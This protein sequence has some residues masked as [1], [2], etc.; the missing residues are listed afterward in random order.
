MP[1]AKKKTELKKYYCFMEDIIELLRRMELFQD[2]IIS[3]PS[4]IQED[5]KNIVRSRS[6]LIDNYDEYDIQIWRMRR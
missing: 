2:E 5:L 6:F 4:S 3:R 1:V